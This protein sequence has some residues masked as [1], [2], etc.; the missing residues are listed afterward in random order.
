MQLKHTLAVLVIAAAAMFVGA[1]VANAV[2]QY[3]AQ[4]GRTCDNCH[5]I[6][7]W[8]TPK[9][10]HRKRN[11]SCNACH[12]DP[13]GGGMRTTAGRYF[14]KST[15]PMIAT[16]PRPQDDWDH[17]FPGIGR[18]DKVTPYEAYMPIGPRNL[19]Q[20]AAYTDSIRTS[21]PEACTTSSH[22]PRRSPAVTSA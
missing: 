7:D 18:R 3:S 13:A 21:G 2:P 17:N 10:A 15:L 11:M 16:S 22:P 20:A 1:R 19:E 14:G 5:I 12:V 8:D 9:L 6:P 4:A